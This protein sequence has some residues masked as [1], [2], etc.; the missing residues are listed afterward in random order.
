[1][2][3]SEQRHKM[4]TIDSCQRYWQDQLNLDNLFLAIVRKKD[5]CHVGNITAAVD[6]TKLSAD[7]GIL[8][9]EKLANGQGYGKEAWY[10]LMKHLFFE[11]GIKTIT[12]GAMATNF[13]MISIFKNCGMMLAR[14]TCNDLGLSGVNQ[15]TV[16][17]QVDAEEWKPCISK[18]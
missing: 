14:T 8:I 2:Q 6:K 18:L 4:H 1:M 5:A 9:G 11:K 7:L 17:Y 15:A 12:G 16:F 3:F 13:P 10:A